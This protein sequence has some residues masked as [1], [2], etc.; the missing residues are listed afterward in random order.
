[1]PPF[2]LVDAFT[3]HPFAGNPAGVVLLDAAADDGWMATVAAE[4]GASETAFV[5][6]SGAERSLRWFTPTVEVDLCGH[7]TLAAAHVIWERG[8]S[9]GTLRFDTRSGTLSATRHDDGSIALDLP[10]WPIEIDGPAPTELAGALRG[11]EHAY[12]G[13]TGGAQPN[14]VAEVDDESALRRIRPDLAA[15]AALGS[16][17]LIVTAPGDGGTDL[18]SRYFAPAV[19]VDEDPVTGSA[20]CTLGPLWAQ[21]LGRDELTAR[22]VSPRGGVLTV[23]VA[24]DRVHVGGR[25][26]TVIDGTVLGP[27]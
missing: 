7:A 2:A 20:H 8:A 10:A 18:V 3:D 13:R 17:G 15:V 27:I 24:G 26:I 11:I 14:D 25:A 12:L 23:R 21:R 4:V 1:M 22:Q 19:G 5:T 16:T 9:E 6:G